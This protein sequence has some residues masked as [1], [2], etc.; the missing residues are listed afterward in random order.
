MTDIAVTTKPVAEGDIVRLKSGGAS[1]TVWKSANASGDVKCI[2]LSSDGYRQEG[3][4]PATVLVR[5][6]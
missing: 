5:A 6:D 4:F 2:W 1:M 3:F